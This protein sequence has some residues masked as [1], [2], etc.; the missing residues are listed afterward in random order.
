VGG[1]VQYNLKESNNRTNTSL[2]PLCH[3]K[4]PSM[5]TFFLTSRSTKEDRAK[6]ATSAKA[7]GEVHRGHCLSQTATIRCGIH[8]NDH[9]GDLVVFTREPD[10][11]AVG[12]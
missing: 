10:A 5:R 8:A 1:G 11:D 4:H 3:G 6:S 12:S 2:E 9:G 7:L